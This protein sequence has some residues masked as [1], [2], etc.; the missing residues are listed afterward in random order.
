MQQWHDI[1]FITS[2]LCVMRIIKPDL[3]QQYCGVAKLRFMQLNYIYKP[4]VKVI[5]HE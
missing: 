1:F 4:F 5:Y 2:R 3:Q